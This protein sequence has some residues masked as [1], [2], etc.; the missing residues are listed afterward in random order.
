MRIFGDPHCPISGILFYASWAQKF[1]Q[2]QM[3][4]K[5]HLEWAF[6][7]KTFPAT[8]C[9]NRGILKKL[10]SSEQLLCCA[11][12]LFGHSFKLLTFN[13]CPY[14]YGT[15]HQ[16]MTSHLSSILGIHIRAW[17][18]VFP[19]RLAWRDPATTHRSI[20]DD[21]HLFLCKEQQKTLH[22]NAVALCQIVF[23]F[24]YKFIRLVQQFHP[25]TISMVDWHN[26]Q[27]GG[28]V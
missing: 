7:F 5:L 26:L 8:V 21:L 18:R 20:V 15:H 14:I 2:A 6:I 19:N 28:I 9:S 12:T 11:M 22:I 4:D 1:K 25:V 16:K 10:V 27:N 24:C 13:C 17:R 23:A 3:I